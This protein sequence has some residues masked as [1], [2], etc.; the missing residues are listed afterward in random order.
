[1]ISLLVSHGANLEAV[2]ENNLTPLHFALSSDFRKC[3]ATV[4]ALLGF[5]ASP[6]SADSTNT[7][8]LHLASWQG[9]VKIISLLASH[10]ANIEAVDYEN[11][12]PLHFALSSGSRNR[13]AAV[14]ALLGLGANPNA[15]D[16]T[17]TTALYLIG[18]ALMIPLLVSHG[19]NL[20]AVQWDRVIRNIQIRNGVY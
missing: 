19:V 1:M 6:N 9:N 8:A 7:T 15:A 16:S 5:G 12:T 3:A 17:N 20:E 11:R 2:D 4:R 10:G 18:D 13:V 14:R